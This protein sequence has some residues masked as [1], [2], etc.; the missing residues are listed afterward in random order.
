MSNLTLFHSNGGVPDRLPKSTT[1]ALQQVRR[2]ALVTAARV[3]AAAFVT[4][5]GLQE[6]EMLSMQE[7]LLAQRC[8]HAV[9]RAQALVDQFTAT[10]VTEV[11]RMRC[12]S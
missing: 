2:T 5:I 10:T 8:P 12:R 6:I 1:R 4:H 11:A 3:E 9:V 7:A